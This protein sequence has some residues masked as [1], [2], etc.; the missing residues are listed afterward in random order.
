M[1]EPNKRHGLVCAYSTINTDTLIKITKDASMPPSF[2]DLCHSTDSSNRSFRINKT[3]NNPQQRRQSQRDAP[4]RLRAMTKVLTNK[5]AHVYNACP[6]S[7][8]NYRAKK[9]PIKPDSFERSK[10]EIATSIQ[11]CKSK[12]NECNDKIKQH[13]VQVPAMRVLRN[14]LGDEADNYYMRLAFLRLNE[15]NNH[16]KQRENVIRL[17]AQRIKSAAIELVQ[18]AISTGVEKAEQEMKRQVFE[19]A[20]KLDRNVERWNRTKSMYNMKS[21]SNLRGSLFRLPNAAKYKSKLLQKK[22][23]LAS[24]NTS[25]PRK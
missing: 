1:N 19:N 18:K 6:S 7:I 8:R 14:L 21:D 22:K 10:L 23:P 16:L 2:E 15:Y 5:T 20:A 17:T 13:T 25:R 4:I 9:P 12:L 3:K 24:G 11:E